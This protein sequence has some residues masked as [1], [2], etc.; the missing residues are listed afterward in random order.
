MH[1]VQV[2]CAYDGDLTRPEALLARYDTLGAWSEALLAA[3]AIRAT[4]VQRFGRDE[5]VERN[6]VRFLFRRDGGRPFPRPWARLPRLARAVAET[7]PDVVHVNGLVSPGAIRGLRGA[8]RAPARLVVQDHAS[9][10]PPRDAARRALWRSGLRAAD[11]FLFTAREQAEPWR[12]AGL[13]GPDQAVLEVPEASRTVLP[14]PRD[15]ARVE[16]RLKG[17][18]A[19]VWI[20][21]LDAN[22]DPMTVLE[23][24][25]QALAELPRAFLTLVY[26][27]DALRAALEARL[28]ADPA[29]A[30]R[31]E[32]R[33]AVEPRGVATLLSAADVF[34]LGSH[35]EGSG[36]ALLEAIACGAAPVVTDIPAHRALTGGGR[37]GC[38]SDVPPLLW[39]VGDP[40]AFRD[41]LV[42]VCRGRLD[43]VRAAV[44]AH[45]ER[46]LCWPAVGRRALAAYR[47]VPEASPRR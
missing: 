39:K 42:R 11:A 33:G 22:K 1:I 29:L 41:A 17:E 8:L 4:V 21:H 31:V 14:R 2:S 19:V 28:A 7:G 10:G 13:I 38:P 15:Q 35:K 20:G 34:V 36:Y 26:R 27:G 18:P 3:G 25:A 37:L 6:G 12:T 32:L 23:G 43:L 47:A 30:A 9:A 24:F 40:V 44:R 46:E 5:E 16:S 45:F